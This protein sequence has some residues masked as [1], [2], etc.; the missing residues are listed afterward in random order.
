M[1]KT[2]KDY[3]GNRTIFVYDITPIALRNGTLRKRN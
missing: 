2:T 3:V 1:E